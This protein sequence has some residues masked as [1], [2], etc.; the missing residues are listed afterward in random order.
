M[1]SSFGSASKAINEAYAAIIS[2][3]KQ[4]TKLMEVEFPP[5]PTDVLESSD[6]SVSNLDSVPA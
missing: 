4:G 2:A 5:L 3:Q 1:I 6:C